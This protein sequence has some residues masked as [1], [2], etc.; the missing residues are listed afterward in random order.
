MTRVH[1]LS[2]TMTLLGSLQH[3]VAMTTE[4][5]RPALGRTLEAMSGLCRC[6]GLADDVAT[7]EASTM[8]AL[9]PPGECGDGAAIDEPEALDAGPSG[10]P[11]VR[12]TS[13]TTTPAPEV[14][15]RP[16]GE[17]RRRHKAT[18]DERRH[19]GVQ[20]DSRVDSRCTT[21]TAGP[22]KPTVVRMKQRPE[23]HFDDARREQRR[24]AALTAADRVRA[25]ERRRCRTGSGLMM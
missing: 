2:I 10:L 15:G 22:T 7:V 4:G 21:T 11:R 13:A 18:C 16:F 8:D 6:P 1:N 20:R 25:P 19:R 5:S 23:R 12:S 24:F 14:G 9:V 3:V 17:G